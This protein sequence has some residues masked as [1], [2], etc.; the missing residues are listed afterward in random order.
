MKRQGKREGKNFE[1]KTYFISSERLSAEAF[2][3]AIQGHWSIENQLNWVKDVT[4]KEDK[5]PRWGSFSR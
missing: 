2:L 4:L 3:K 1:E 5:P